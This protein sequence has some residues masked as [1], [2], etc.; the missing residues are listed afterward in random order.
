MATVRRSAVGAAPSP[1]SVR[2]LE[3]DHLGLVDLE[4]RH[5]GRPGQPV[6]ARVEAGRQ[7]DGLPDARLRRGLE[8][9]VEETRAGGH[10]VGHVLELPG[11]LLDVDVGGGEVAGGPSGEEVHADGAHQRLGEPVLD[12]RVVGL[13]GDRPGGRHH[14]GRRSD[15]GGQVPG[16]V[17]CAWHAPA[18]QVGVGI[19]SQ[20]NDRRAHKVPAL[21]HPVAARL[22][23]PGS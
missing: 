23:I 10:R 19:L 2:R 20:Y 6:G 22:D 8:E 4:H 11:G 13:R 5:A 14:R 9:R 15:A 12:H 21:T 7:D 16:V 3:L 18:L 17:V 1:A